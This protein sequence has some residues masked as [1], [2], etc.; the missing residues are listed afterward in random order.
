MSNADTEIRKATVVS[1]G[2]PGIVETQPVSQ[3]RW[4]H[5]D[6]LSPNNYNPNHMAPPEVALLKI[7]ILEDGWTQPIVAHPKNE[8]GVYEIVDGFHRYLASGEPELMEEYQGWV[9][10]ALAPLDPVHSKMSTI[11]HNRARGVH[12]VQPMAEIL[13]TMIEEGI[14]EEEIQQRLQMEPEETM[15]LLDRSGMVKKVGEKQSGFNSSWS[16]ARK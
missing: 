3:I 15:R 6:E 11:R 9:P 10:I 12:G 14:P 1:G 8:E 2:P 13:R 5:R 7:S 4:V 16:P